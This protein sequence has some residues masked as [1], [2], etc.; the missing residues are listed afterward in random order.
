MSNETNGLDPIQNAIARAFQDGQ[1]FER[2]RILNTLGTYLCP[3]PM[4]CKHN[5]CK[6]LAKYALAIHGECE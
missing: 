5:E 2:D 4:E 3:N 6:N 1:V